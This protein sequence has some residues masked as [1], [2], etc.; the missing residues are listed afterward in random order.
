ME[1]FRLTKL[2]AKLGLKTLVA[3]AA[4][5]FSASASALVITPTTGPAVLAQALV[6]M[7]TG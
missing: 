1:D 6:T 4:V 7:E 5:A 2:I 3:A